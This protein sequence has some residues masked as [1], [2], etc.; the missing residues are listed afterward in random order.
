MRPDQLAGDANA[1][2]WF[3]QN[4]HTMPV[5][6][7]GLTPVQ[8]TSAPGSYA[9]GPA[10]SNTAKLV[11]DYIASHGLQANQSD[12]AALRDIVTYLRT[13]G[14]NAQ[15]DYTDSNGH[16]GGILVN[17]Q[18]YQLID[19][20]NRWTALQPWEASG[21]GGGGDLG[22]LGAGSLLQPFTENFSR[23]PFKPPPDFVAPTGDQVFEDPGFKFRLDQGRQALERSAAAKGTLLTTG[24][25]K[26]LDSFSQGAA[27]QEYGNVYARRAGEY[28][29][30][31]GKAVD[32]YSRDYNQALGEYGI[33]QNNFYANQDRPFSKLSTLA[34]FGSLPPSNY[35]SQYGSLMLNGA[36]QQGSYLTGAANANAAGLVGGANA[37]TNAFGNLS[38][39]GAQYASIYSNPWN[40]GPQQSSGWQ[41]VPYR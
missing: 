37:Y 28:E 22:G 35:A 23:E 11:A 27:S 13:Q 2:D 17:N 5:A 38:N 18:P 34:G 24:T 41:G 36:N 39:L 12:P 33:K 21:G 26:D 32:T 4:F 6:T 31:Y 19:G 16:T 7:A 10:D 9:S 3:A 29:S 14:V 8:A 40:R 1:P 30:S 25:L 15:V 20:S